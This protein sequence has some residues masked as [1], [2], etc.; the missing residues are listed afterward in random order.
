MNE[1]CFINED[2]QRPK[3]AG[4]KHDPLLDVPTRPYLDLPNEKD[5]TNTTTTTST[6]TFAPYDPDLLDLIVIPVSGKACPIILAP[7]TTTTTTTT[8]N[9][10]YVLG[11]LKGKFN[12]SS[13]SILTISEGNVGISLP[14]SNGIVLSNISYNNAGGDYF[15]FMAFGYFRPPV[16]GTYTFST[17]SD[18]GSAIWL[19]VLAEIDVGRN[20]TNALLNNNVTGSQGSTKKSASILLTG[21]TFYPIRIVHREAAGGDNLTFSWSGPNIEETTDLTEYFYYDK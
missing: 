4:K 3:L 20:I 10:L 15:S 5:S 19:G 7:P 21:N 16:N 2:C 9:P 6:T 14:I 18:D 12:M 13:D 11:G 8:I 17:A 1:D